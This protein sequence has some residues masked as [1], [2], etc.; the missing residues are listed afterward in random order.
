MN[1]K[2]IWGMFITFW[3]CVI[4]GVILVATDV[5]DD[6]Y[7][8]RVY[9]SQIGYYVSSEMNNFNSIHE[10]EITSKEVY[11]HFSLFM[12]FGFEETDLLNSG[13]DV[14]IYRINGQLYV[15]ARDIEKL[16]NAIE[17]E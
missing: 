9:N 16:V 11:G 10:D 4:I 1:Y 7:Y 8:V 2:I 17:S 5:T 6:G 3:L 15:K 12:N 14:T 13:D